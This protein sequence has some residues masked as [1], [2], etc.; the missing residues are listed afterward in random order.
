MSTELAAMPKCKLCKVK[1]DSVNSLTTFCS[2]A[3]A[4]EW[5]QSPAGK[6]ATEKA[7]HKK[8]KADDR[9]QKEKKADYY[10]R[11]VS[12]QHKHTQIAFN[13]MRKLEELLWFRDGL[14]TTNKPGT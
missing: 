13:K 6:H 2:P 1:F 12:W 3:H 5:L 11:H 8:R 4:I 9:A 7:G 14:R 10:R